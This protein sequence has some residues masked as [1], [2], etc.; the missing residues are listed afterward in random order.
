L[1]PA[2]C[3]CKGRDSCICKRCTVILHLWLSQRQLY[4]VATIFWG[5]MPCSLVHVRRL[6][7]GS[8]Y[9]LLHCCSC[10]L[11]GLLLDHDDEGN[12]FLRNVG[13]FLPDYTASHP[14]RQYSATAPRIVTCGS[15]PCADRL[16]AG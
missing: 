5:V 14:G 11:L 3:P 4:E 16:R 6:F 10:W 7:G 15:C 12:M 8:Y 13:E 1:F 9:F 2:R